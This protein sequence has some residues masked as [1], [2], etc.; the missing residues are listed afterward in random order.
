MSVCVCVSVCL[1]VFVCV[2]RVPI[3][4]SNP[5]LLLPPQ[6]DFQRSVVISQVATQGAREM[7]R[8]QYVLNYT[9][10]Y[11]TDRRKWTYYKGDSYHFAMMVRDHAP[12]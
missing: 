10:S 2:T 3:P 5:P 8:S 6:V 7:F 1:Y 4:I 11:S 9:I 12:A